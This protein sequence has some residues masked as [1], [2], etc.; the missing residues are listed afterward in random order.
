MILDTE[1]EILRKVAWEAAA[2]AMGLRASVQPV[3]A[4]DSALARPAPVF[5]TW[6]KDGRSRGRSG[7]VGAERALAVEVEEHA[8]AAL[9]HDPRFPPAAV[10]ELPRYVPEISVLYSFEEISGAESL[11]PGTH[12]VVVEKGKRR[13]VVLPQDGALFDWDGAR[14]LSQACLRAGLPEESW[15]AASPPRLLRFTAEVF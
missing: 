14:I 5:V 13:G 6:K 10:K 11:L 9:L 7:T 8:V 3:I 2:R 15:R 12:G 4:A 1:R